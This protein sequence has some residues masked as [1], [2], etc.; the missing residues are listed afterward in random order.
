MKEVEI[1]RGMVALVD[2]EDFEMVKRYRWFALV[3]KDRDLVYA[4]VKQS[5]TTLLMHR[6]IMN[7]LKCF[8][9]DH[10]DHNGLNNTRDNL[11]LCTASQN[12]G[13]QRACTSRSGI[14]THS[15]F[16]G[17]SFYKKS[18][19]FLAYIKI[20]KKQKYLGS[21]NNEIDAAFAYD[22]KAL[23]VFGDFAYLNFPKK[24]S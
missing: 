6:L 22:R 7:P 8:F 20:G 17:V 16:K 4:A 14:N 23:E 1:S 15:K 10:R 19:R 2:D 24:I 9:V 5:G 13:N 21:F 12:L 3:Y 18:Q 11:R